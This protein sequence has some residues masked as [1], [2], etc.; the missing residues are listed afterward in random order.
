MDLVTNYGGRWKSPG[1]KKKDPYGSVNFLA[2]SPK[3]NTNVT[4]QGANVTT[5]F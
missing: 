4:K 5:L 1:S 2:K 3:I